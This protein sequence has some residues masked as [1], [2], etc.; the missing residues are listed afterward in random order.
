MKNDLY[1]Y[2]TLTKKN[3]LFVPIDNNEIKMYV[4]GPTVY[5]RAHLGNARSVVVYD[6]LFRILKRLFPKVT[7]VRNITDIDDKIINA[8]LKEKVPTKNITEKYTKYFHEDIN[9]LNCLPPSCEPKATENIQNI[10]EL[11]Q[12][13]MD[14]GCAYLSNGSVYFSV[15]SIPN[16]GSILSKRIIDEQQASGRIQENDDKRDKRDF[17]LW[18]I[19]KTDAVFDSPWGKGRP[20]WHIECSAMTIANFGLNFDIHG[21]GLDLCFPHHENEIAQVRAGHKN[22]DYA[23]YWVHNGFLKVN[24]EKMS[25]SLGNFVTVADLI[26]KK[27]N[28]NII[29]YA[30][31]TTNYDQPLDWTDE[32]ITQTKNNLNK[33]VK[34]YKK[35]KDY[36]ADNNEIYEKCWEAL[37]DNINTSKA[38][39]SLQTLANEV[40]NNEDLFYQLKNSFEFMGFQI[41]SLIENVISTDVDESKITEMIDLRKKAKAEK[42]FQKA[43]EIRNELKRMGVILKDNSDGTVNWNYEK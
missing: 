4:C 25:K 36:R 30:L 11:I 16:Y 23:R 35:F 6:L 39:M 14:N 40:G 26:D 8:A 42:N 7:Y 3:E 13:I 33:I 43:D 20:G 15:P 28:G 24:G 38:L 2:N 31:L 1:L 37:L 17:V 19:E 12:R 32:L 9:Y 41:E 22:A 5:D 10:I 18:K 27:I 21:G 29:R 34:L